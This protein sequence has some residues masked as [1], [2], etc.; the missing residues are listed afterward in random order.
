MTAAFFDIDKFGTINNGCGK[1]VSNRILHQL[2]QSL[3]TTI[4]T[5]D[6]AGRYAGQQFLAMVLDIG[7]KETLK[8]AELWRQTIEKTIFLYKTEP[9][10]IT[11][12]GAVSI[13]EPNNTY[14]GGLGAAGKD[15][16][17]G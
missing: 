14:I 12:S 16:E 11:V 9:I 5:V 15:H 4:G 8:K 10:D 3:Q 13:V 7:P 2:A 17:A 6:I 1:V